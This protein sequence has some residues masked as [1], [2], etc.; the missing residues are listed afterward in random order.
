[1]RNYVFALL[2]LTIAGCKKNEA[3]IQVEDYGLPSVLKKGINL[4]NWFNDYSDPAQYGTR[5]TEAHFQAIKDMG[6][7]Y[8]RIPVG[9]TVLYNPYN[10]Y[11]LKSNNFTFVRNAIFSAINAGLGVMINYHPWKDDYERQLFNQSG[12]ITNLAIYWQTLAAALKDIDP[13]F[14]FFEVYNEPHVGNYEGDSENGWQWWWQNQKILIEAIRSETSSHFI[15]AG[16]EG[17][18]NID[19]LVANTPYNIKNVIYNFHFYT[20]FEFTHQGAEWVGEPWQELNMVPYPSTPENVAPLIAATENEEI[21]NILYYYGQSRWNNIKLIELLRPVSNWAATYHVPVICNE[22]GVY[23]P[24]APVS[25]RQI[26]LLETRQA[27][28]ENGFGWAM[29]ECDEGFGLLEYFG[30]DRSEFSI[31]TEIVKAL[32]L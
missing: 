27:L 9:H 14:L 29:W 13:A 30:F 28:E 11:L 31:D 21:K 25:D 8:V 24:K 5:F 23:K 17:W 6:F 12:E 1:M 4:S 20:P 15:I 7:S 16:A 10:P 2:C 22:F 18:N 3:A 32:G 19:Y 26:Y